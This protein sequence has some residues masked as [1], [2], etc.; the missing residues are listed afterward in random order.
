MQQQVLGTMFALVIA[1]ADSIDLQPLCCL[2][3]DGPA[4]DKEPRVL[5]GYQVHGQGYQA[6]HL[7]SDENC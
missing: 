3:Q 2:E 1:W 6:Y 7:N 5:R 4:A